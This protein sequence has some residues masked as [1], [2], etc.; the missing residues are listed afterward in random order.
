MYG[1]LFMRL[2]GVVL[3]VLV[4]G[5]LLINLVLDG[6]IHADRLRLR[7]RQVGHPVLAGL[8]PADAVARDAA[9]R[10]RPAHDHQRLRASATNTRLWLK[11]L[12]YTAHGGHHRCWARW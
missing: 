3:V 12:L 4:F 5:H 2:S 7:R 11:G 6:G 1:W 10:Q 9:R 8:G